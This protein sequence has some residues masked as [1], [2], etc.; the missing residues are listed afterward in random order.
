M[1]KIVRIMIRLAAVA[2]K[3]SSRAPFAIRNS[4]RLLRDEINFKMSKMKKYSETNQIS[5]IKV[6][7]YRV[8]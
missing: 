2:I 8:K 6:V 4:W 3:R 5:M 7:K 1:N